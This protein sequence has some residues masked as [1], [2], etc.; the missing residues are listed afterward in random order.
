MGNQIIDNITV[1]DKKKINVLSKLKSTIKTILKKSNTNK[2]IRND[3]FIIVYSRNSQHMQQLDINSIDQK[4]I[5]F[6]SLSGLFDT[7]RH[8]PP[9]KLFDAIF[10]LP[11]KKKWLY[12]PSKYIKEIQNSFIYPILCNKFTDIDV[13]KEFI[14]L[15]RWKDSQRLVFWLLNDY[16]FVN[17]NVPINVSPVWHNL[18]KMFSNMEDAITKTKYLPLIL[19]DTWW[20]DKTKYKSNY[21]VNACRILCELYWVTMRYDTIKEIIYQSNPLSLNV[22][23]S[24]QPGIASNKMITLTNREVFNLY[25]TVES[26][27][28]IDVCEHA[29]GMW[30]ISTDYDPFDM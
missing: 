25:G 9:I 4:R 10:I 5:V 26:D 20:E 3:D 23:T 1:L 22:I 21:D 29:N 13:I 6:I 27:Y 8:C 7:W 28:E 2:L 18:S 19:D 12:Y 15:V 30:H 16:D 24:Y 17:T 11:L 14:Q